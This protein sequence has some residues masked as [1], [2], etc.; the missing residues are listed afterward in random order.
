M[1][2]DDGDGLILMTK[3]EP[4]VSVSR[5]INAPASALF[6]CLVRPALHAE[7]DGSGMLRG[8]D[9]RQVLSGIGDVFEMRMFNDV[10]G[11]YLIENH[12]VEFEPDRRIA[13]E[14]VVKATEKPEFQSRVG[15]RAHLRWRW[16][17][18]PLPDGGTRVTESY[19]LSAAPQW[20]H[21]ATKE[22]EDW[23]PAMEAS[24]TNLAKLVARPS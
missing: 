24:L 21:V 4:S 10:M 8:T 6:N 5:D 7:I 3:R 11:D 19:D 23:R 17:L 15:D 22:G 12:I 20:L 1:I 18:S 2:F 13:W 9:D 14:P 16:E